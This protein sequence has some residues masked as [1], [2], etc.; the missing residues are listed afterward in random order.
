MGGPVTLSIIHPDGYLEEKVL[1]KHLTRGEEPIVVV[2]AHTW[3]GAHPS[4][5]EWSLVGNTVA[6]GFDYQDWELGNATILLRQYPQH[7]SV[8]R[9]LT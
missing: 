2:P 9:K 5:N 8:I 1:G 7:V 4:G 6:P 3:F